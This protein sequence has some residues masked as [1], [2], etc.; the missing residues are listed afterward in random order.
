[1]QEYRVFEPGIPDF[2]RHAFAASLLCWMTA[3]LVF[4]AAES[5]VLK[6]P[7][8]VGAYWVA[9]GFAVV[10]VV[11]VASAA[12]GTGGFE[13]IFWLLLGG[14]C[15]SGSRDTF[16]GPGFISPA[17]MTRRCSRPTICSTPF[18]ICS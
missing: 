17:F 13:K 1:M 9:A 10:A 11:A 12:R 8:T 4:A 15:F 16:P 2:V 18:P 6:I 3:A 5:S 14:G 7:A